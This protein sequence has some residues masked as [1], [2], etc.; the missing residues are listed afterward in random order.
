MN[1]IEFIPARTENILN[2]KNIDKTNI[3]ITMFPTIFL[4]KNFIVLN[5]QTKK[6]D[7]SKT[8]LEK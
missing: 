3:A 5:I 2:K 4:K 7:F 1:N 8:K 6:F